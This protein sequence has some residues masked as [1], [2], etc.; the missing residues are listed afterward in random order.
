MVVCGLVLGHL[1][2]IAL[3]FWLLVWLFSP[4][5]FF[6]LV[7]AFVAAVVVAVVVGAGRWAGEW[8][9][10]AVQIAAVVG[11]CAFY[12]AVALYGFGVGIGDFATRAAIGTPA[13][14][15]G[16]SLAVGG[17]AVIAIGVLLAAV[18]LPVRK[19]TASVVA[20]VTVVAGLGGVAG[21]GAVGAVTDTCDAFRP[22]PARWRMALRA[23]ST[24][25]RRMARAIDN[26]GT[27]DGARRQTVR[28]LLGGSEP[29]SR[30]EWTWFLGTTGGGL[31]GGNYEDLVV[32]FGRD[33]RAQRV[34][35]RTTVD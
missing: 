35:V 23:H 2:I 25:A 32:T 29:F 7:V 8:W 13:T 20:A 17:G 11:L 18:P 16:A 9:C 33:G 30:R 19:R 22:D 12:A 27:I 21:A 6:A 1:A 5:A 3:G 26:C 28:G 24:D 4:L 34:Y 14:D 10:R 15:I 31:F